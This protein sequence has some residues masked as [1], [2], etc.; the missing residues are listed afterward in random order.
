MWPQARDTGAT[1]SWERQG[2]PSPGASEGA[3]PCDTLAPEFW[4]PELGENTLL[5]L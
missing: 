4:A 1:R 5:L 2:G 3:R